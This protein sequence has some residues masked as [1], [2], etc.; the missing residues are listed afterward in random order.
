MVLIVGRSIMQLL[1]TLVRFLTAHSLL[2][3]LPTTT[4]CR[5]LSAVSGQPL[6]ANLVV[7]QI[8]ISIIQPY[9]L[10]GMVPLMFLYFF[11]Q[12]YYR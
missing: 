2:G 11:V 6:T 10:A 12:K 9:F 8:F 1:S 5:R 3:Q 7:L 4:D